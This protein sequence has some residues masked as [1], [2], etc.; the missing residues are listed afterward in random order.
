MGAANDG[1]RFMLEVAVLASL[2]YSGFT[3]RLGAMRWVAGIGLPLLVAV[4]WAVFVNPEGSQATDDPVRLLLEV[5]VFGSGVAAL[6]AVG[7]R[8][9]AVILAALVVLHLVLTFALDQR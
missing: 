8:R 2:G 9:L 6:A 3:S 5:A 1:L 7:R 4:V